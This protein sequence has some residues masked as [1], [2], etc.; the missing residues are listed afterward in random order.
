MAE[1][2]LD[3]ARAARAEANGEAPTVKFGG[4]VFVLP[5]EMP[6]QIVESVNAMQA[7]SE[8]GDGYTVTQMLS[9]IAKDLFGD[10]FEEFLSFHPS[11]LDM[12][13]LLENVAPMYGLTAGESQASE[14]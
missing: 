1:F 5:V 12:Q 13:A 11:M 6:Y 3:A 7:A 14:G 10:R 4:V 2:D 8:K 9:A